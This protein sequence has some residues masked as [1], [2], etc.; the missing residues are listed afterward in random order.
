M[1][2]S[3]EGVV[4]RC[5]ARLHVNVLQPWDE[6]ARARRLAKPVRLMR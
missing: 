3:G 2:A 5:V 1:T 4:S 6:D